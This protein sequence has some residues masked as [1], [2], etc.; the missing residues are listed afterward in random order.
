MTE[1]PGEIIA[2]GGVALRA[3]IEQGVIGALLALSLIA[4]AILVWRLIACYRSH[5]HEPF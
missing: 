4:N 2:V 3:I 1:V 5:N